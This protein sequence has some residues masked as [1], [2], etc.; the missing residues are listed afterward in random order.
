[1]RIPLNSFVTV[2]S[3]Q[4]SEPANLEKNGRPPPVSGINFV[5][6]YGRKD[7]LLVTVTQRGC[8]AQRPLYT[9]PCVWFEKEGN[10]RNCPNL[11]KSKSAKKFNL[12]GSNVKINIFWNCFDMTHY[13]YVITFFEPE[14]I[15]TKILR[16]CFLLEAWLYPRHHCDHLH[17]SLHS[18]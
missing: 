13:S 16:G 17:G 5:G 3:K 6:Y 11:P 8:V 1:M 15:L 9:S 4:W 12:L 14:Y 2:D 18:Q 10:R 7:D